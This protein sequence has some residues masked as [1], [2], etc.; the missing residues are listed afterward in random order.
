MKISKIWILFLP[1]FFVQTGSSAEKKSQPAKSVQRIISA[2]VNQVKGDKSLMFKQ[3]VGAGRANEGLRSDWQKQL[4]EIKKDCD[5]KKIR[6]H[7]LFNEDM[8][9]YWEDKDGAHYNWQY[10]DALYDFLVAADVKPFV[11][12]AFMPEQL[13]SGGEKIFWWGGNVTP[14]NNYQKWADLVKNFGLHLKERYGEKEVATWYFEVWNEPNLSGFFTG[15]QE[16]YFKL[17]E[18]S[19]RAIKEASPLFR[20]GGPAAAGLVW[21]KEIMEFCKKGNVPLD[22]VSAHQYGVDGYLDEYGVNQLRIGY[23]PENIP[24]IV[25]TACSD[26]RK[27]IY[28]NMEFHITEWNSSYSSRDPIHDTYQNA[29]YVLNTLKH[30]EGGPNSMSYWT[31]TDIFEEAGVA[32]TPFHGGFGLINIGGIKKPTYFAYKFLNE[33]GNVELQNNDKYSWICKNE[34]GDLQA[35]FYNITIQDMKKESNQVYFKRNIPA[36]LKEDVVL[37]FSNVSNGKY[38]REIYRIGY[39]FNDPYTVYYEMGSPDFLS[40][41]QTKALMDSSNG[42]AIDRKVIEIVDGAYKESY[43]VRENDIFFVKLIKL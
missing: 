27:S 15:S 17:Y 4:L 36:M 6:F 37:S 33:L 32:H 42:D 7:A 19:A 30:A 43:S 28:P 9:V 38:L 18:Y 24:N 1:F 12:L 20:V 35:L 29:S 40:K 26:I 41:S 21:I 16:D 13:K 23:D 3:C 22:F 5:F 34:S 10:I 25:N 11:E 39:K 2:D 14:P 31:F 8:G